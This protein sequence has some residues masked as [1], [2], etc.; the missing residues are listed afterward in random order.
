MASTAF[1]K[2]LPQS[3][4]S[5]T[6]FVKCA[7][8]PATLA[9]RRAILKGLAMTGKTPGIEVF[10]RLEDSSSFI[11]VTNTAATANS[12]VADS[13]FTRY[14]VTTEPEA[15]AALS[16]T[17]WSAAFR[18]TI[19]Q[20][21]SVQT[22]VQLRN[23]RK[24]KEKTKILEK[25]AFVIHIFP[26]NASYNHRRAV[27]RS[28][29]HGPW[30][31]P[32]AKDSFMAAALRRIIPAGALAPSLRDWDTGHQLFP[33][34]GVST[35][36]DDQSA[37]NLVGLGMH[38]DAYAR[39]RRRRRECWHR[40][41]AVMKSLKAVSRLDAPTKPLVDEYPGMPG[42]RGPLGPITRDTSQSQDAGSPFRINNRES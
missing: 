13:P 37:W 33:G 36:F 5:R 26:A 30:P 39:E 9:E 19:T 10:K 1:A 32:Q 41:P 2:A 21:I 22:A 12:L 7:P 38:G 20:P 40:T 28:V 17:T 15:T 25:K 6:L 29:L 14:V 42:P 11:A 18:R 16:T 27:G 31:E 24:T 23:M 4:S 3:L 8:A 35:G 34:R